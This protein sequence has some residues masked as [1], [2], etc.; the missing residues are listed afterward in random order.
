M[1]ASAVIEMLRERG[2]RI[3][4][5]RREIVEA[6][7][8]TKGHILPG[9]IAEQVRRK[10][11]GV[12]ESTVYRTLSVL[13]DAGVL[14]HAHLHGGP[15]YHHAGAH[16]HVHLTCTTCGTDSFLRVA[17]LEEMKSL[18]KRTT[19]FDPDFTHFAVAGTCRSCFKR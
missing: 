14:S 4:D 10:M 12:D 3:T 17:E 1:D 9:A 18:M 8:L 5:Q 6:V 13:E 11:P 19:G 2:H 16:D 15:E 7:M